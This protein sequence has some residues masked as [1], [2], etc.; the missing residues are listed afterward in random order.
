MHDAVSENRAVHAERGRVRGRI[1][2]IAKSV[3]LS[4]MM[5]LFVCSAAVAGPLLHYGIRSLPLDP[6]FNLPYNPQEVQF[7]SI[8]IS[9]VGECA[10]L[11]GSL[12]HGGRV[13]VFGELHN[14]HGRVLIL[15]DEN[16]NAQRGLS[17]VVLVMR[18]GGCRTSG[19][20]VALRRT[21]I[22]DPDLD[23]GLSQAD[24]SMLMRDIFTRYSRAFGTKANFLQ[25]A[26]RLTSEA[27][28]AQRESPDMPCPLL[29]TS[30]FSTP[31]IHNL[32]EFRNS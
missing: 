16:P 17:G 15:G 20:L 19:P 7:D 1:S 32:T 3:A 27:E 25:W 11:L 14:G 10:P 22:S 23:P 12:G 26:D 21:P 29:Y 8:P 24:V 2:A 13:K 31:M 18:G 6:L 5:G 9:S 4:T 30:M 28:E